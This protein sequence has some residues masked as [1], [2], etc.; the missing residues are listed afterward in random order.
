MGVPFLSP[1]PLI[2][3]PFAWISPE[4]RRP[5][6]LGLVVAT[7]GVSMLMRASGAALLNAS[8]P[9]GI[10]SLELARTPAR[11]TQIMVSWVRDG[12]IDAAISNVKLD[13]LFLLTY[14]PT[15]ALACLLAMVSL[16]GRPRLAA[17]GPLVG[18]GSLL[19][20]ALDALENVGLLQMLEHPGHAEESWAFL[21]FACAVPK[22]ILVALGLLYA[23]SGAFAR[24][25]PPAQ[26]G[27][28]S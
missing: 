17:I 27:R 24:L 1:P 14:A 4:R 2:R 15:I 8:A 23:G 16:E 5:A 7:L 9:A 3:H 22:F 21:A 12:A 18:L 6:L 10:V 26:K 13:Y 11:A 20:G 28:D 25:A 19:A